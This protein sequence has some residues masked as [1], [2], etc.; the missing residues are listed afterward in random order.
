M[1]VYS[2]KYEVYKCK[3]NNLSVD[4][5]YLNAELKRKLMIRKSFCAVS[6]YVGWLQLFIKSRSNEVKVKAISLHKLW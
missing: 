4:I 1:N 2:Y 5:V 3:C 6:K